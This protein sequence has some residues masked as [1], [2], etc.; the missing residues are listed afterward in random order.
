MVALDKV[1]CHPAEA[2][3]SI[4]GLGRGGVALRIA[5]IEHHWYYFLLVNL[6]SKVHEILVAA[7]QIGGLMVMHC[8]DCMLLM[9]VTGGNF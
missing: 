1:V 7:Q 9:P 8:T 6:A 3:Q 2:V 5:P 4:L